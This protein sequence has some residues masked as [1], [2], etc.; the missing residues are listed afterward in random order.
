MAKGVVDPAEVVEVEQQ[1]CHQA[2]LVPVEIQLG[3]ESVGKGN[4]VGQPGEGIEVR[5]TLEGIELLPDLVG[6]VVERGGQVAELVLGVDDDIL[7]EL[8]IGDPAGARVEGR[9][10][11]QAPSQLPQA[12]QQCRKQAEDDHD[13]EALPEGRDR[14]HDVGEILA[15]HHPPA[16]QGRT[17]A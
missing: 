17:L 8:L 7:P 1:D 2:T 16:G 11:R 14:P 15:H 9:Q 3:R 12:Q 6:H 13:R 10:W 4:P 5:Q